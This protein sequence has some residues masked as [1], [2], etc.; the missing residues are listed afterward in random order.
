MAKK[1]E[2]EKYTDPELRERIKEE[3][4]QSDKG[5]KKGQWSARKSQLLTQEYEK[6][7]GDYKGEK[8]ESQKNLEKWTDEEWQTQKGGTRARRDDGETKRYLPKKAWENLSEEEK[9]ETEQKKRE[10]SKRGEQHVANTEEARQARKGS[11]AP[12]LKGY[13]DLSVEEVEKKVQGMSTEEIRQ[14]RNYEKGHKNRNTLIESLD[15]KS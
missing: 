4:K 14:V 15:R 11:Q 10:G 13:N 7:G 1:S 5:G 9:R 3:I 12:P 8:D 2:G 6:R